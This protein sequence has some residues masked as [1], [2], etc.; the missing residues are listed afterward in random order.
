FDCSAF[1]LAGALLR[2]RDRVADLRQAPLALGLLGLELREAR[3]L[4]G[5]ALGGLGPFLHLPQALLGLLDRALLLLA[6]AL[7]R[8]LGRLHVRGRGLWGRRHRCRRPDRGDGAGRRREGL[9]GLAGLGLGEPRLRLTLKLLRL[10]DPAVG[11]E[12]DPFL[13]ALDLLDF[14]LNALFG[15]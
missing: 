14:R 12:A 6:F 11:L 7:D 13:L 5:T 8:L 3:G 2:L 15:L 10:L 1:R 9:A 4:G